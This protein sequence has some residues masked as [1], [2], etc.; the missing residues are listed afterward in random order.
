MSEP[1]SHASTR[2][3]PAQRRP[4][5]VAASSTSSP[6]CARADSVV[7]SPAI[8]DASSAAP[9][10]LRELDDATGAD[11]SVVGLDHHQV[12]VGEG[13]D[14]GQVGDHNHLVPPGQLGQPLADLHRHLA[15][16]P[17]VHLVENQRGVGPVGRQAPSP[18][19]AGRGRVH[20][21]RRPRPRLR[22]WPP[23][24]ALKV[25]SIASAPSG[26]SSVGVTIKARRAC[27]RASALSSDSTT[28]AKA[29]AAP[30]RS[31]VSSPASSPSSR[32]SG[33]QLVRERL[34]PVVAVAPGRGVAP[35]PAQPT[36]RPRWPYCRTCG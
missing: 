1:S 19:Q 31:W 33:R 7:S 35:A 16:H 27:G 28:G 15:T 24:L 2:P 32:R 4:R 14:L 8:M 13:R 12:P 36:A 11:L 3:G 23:G 9:V 18:A 5:T 21:R 22:G 30:V 29:A 6:A 34:D 10:P 17:G 25:R 20:R 26:P